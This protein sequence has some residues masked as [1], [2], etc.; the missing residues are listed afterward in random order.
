M[1]VFWS[2]LTKGEATDA[3]KAVSGDISRKK[4]R[5]AV[6]K[7]FKFTNGLILYPATDDELEERKAA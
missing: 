4:V 3:I 1:R 7:A 2:F 5:R 6:P